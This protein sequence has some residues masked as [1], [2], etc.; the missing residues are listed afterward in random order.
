M[1]RPELNSVAGDLANTGVLDGAPQDAAPKPKAD[2]TDTD[3]ELL[4]L[5][6]TDPSA[7]AKKVRA[8]WELQDSPVERRKPQWDANKLALMGFQGVRAR[9]SST[10]VN[11]WELYVPPGA[12][13]R[14]PTLE[15]P[16]VLIDRLVSHLLQDEPKPDCTPQQ[17]TPKDRDAAE[18]AERWLE[19]DG[20]SAATNDA[21]LLRVSEKKAAVFGSGFLYGYADPQGG[22]WEEQGQ[23]W[24]AKIC[25]KPVSTYAVRAVPDTACNIADADGV[26][27]MDRTTVGDLKRRFP[28]TAAWDASQWTKAVDWKPKAAKWM[29]PWFVEM[30]LAKTEQMKADGTPTDG[31]PVV[32]LAYYHKSGPEYQRGAYLLMTGGD[33]LLHSGPWMDESEPGNARPMDLPVVQVKQLTDDL[34]D[35]FY[36][37]GLMQPLGPISEVRC[38]ITLAYLA[39]LDRATYPHTFIPMGSNIQPDQ[40]AQ[41]DGRGLM[42]NAAGQ[43]M[44]E[45]VGRFDPQAVEFLDRARAAEDDVIGVY[46]DAAG[47]GNTAV[48]SGSHA[49]LEVQQSEVNLTQIAQNLRDGIERL[50]RLKMQLARRDIPTEQRMLVVGPDGAYKE[51]AW[52]G[53]DFRSVRDVRIKSGTFTQLAPGAKEQLILQR[54]TMQLPDGSTLL[55]PDEGR[56][57]LAGNMRSD[58]GAKDNPFVTKVRRELAAWREGPAPEWLQQA[59]EADRANQ[60]AQRQWQMQGGEQMQAQGGPPFQPP[61]A[62]PQGPFGRVA[63]D[64]EPDVARLRHAEIRREQVTTTFAQMPPLWQNV[65]NQEYEAMRQAAGITTLAEQAQQQQQQME[66]QQRAAAEQAQ[67]KEAASLQREQV[68]AQSEVTQE[69]IRGAAQVAAAK[70]RAEPAEPAEAPTFE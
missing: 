9:P 48:R 62:M 6:A 35:D 70:E 13:D 63:T 8:L 12:L 65:L 56:R 64:L 61:Y 33:E 22:G 31:C 55:S 53:A 28:E 54:L 59:E 25:F 43:P 57:L 41:R 26:L 40:L 14:P 34:S 24:Q 30:R 52:S 69:Q 10:D 4:A 66:A 29:T 51:R 16:E 60:M 58:I 15:Q 38:M 7:A 49:A 68:K 20:S 3:G 2:A 37:R 5:A 47:A 44:V 19:A 27:V 32:T 42:F 17:D 1:P 39:Y 21:L 46:R 67:A 11:R 50:W 45:Q 36:G 23:R 18:F